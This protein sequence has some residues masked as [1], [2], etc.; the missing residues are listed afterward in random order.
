M[1]ARHGAQRQ[2]WCLSLDNCLGKPKQEVTWGCKSPADLDDGNRELNRK[3][4]H[5]E[6]GSE[7]SGRQSPGPRNTKRV[8]AS[9]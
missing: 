3:G 5:R 7:G 1:C 6:V 9:A 8:E 2:A 4:V